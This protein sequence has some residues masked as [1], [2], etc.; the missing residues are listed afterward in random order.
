M[1]KVTAPGSGPPAAASGKEKR[2]FSKRLFPS[3]R[4]SGGGA[5]DSG[6]SGPAAPS[7]PSS[8][9]SVGSF[10]SRV[11][12]TLSTLSDFSSESAAP[13]RGGL[14]SCFPPGPAAAVPAA[15]RLSRAAKP[16]PGVAGLRNHCNTCFM[17]AMLQCLSNTELFAECLALGQYPA[18]RPEPSPH[19]EQPTGRGAQGQG[20]VTEQLA[21]LVRALWT[22]EYTS[23]HSRDF[24]TIVSKNALQYRGNS[25]HDAQEFLLWLLDRVHEDLNHSVKQSGQPP[26]KPLSETDMMPEGPSFPV[27]S[28]FVQELF[29]AQYRSSLTCPHCQKQSNSFDPF[30]CISLPI[31]LPTQVYQGKCSHCMRIG[32][33]VP[34]SGTVARLREAVS[35]ETKIPT[36]QLD[37][38]LLPCLEKRK[39]SCAHAAS[40][41]GNSFKQQPKPL[42]I[43]LGLS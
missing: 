34:L 31:P 40:L 3:R 9:R 33:A 38:S 26:L 2:S 22:L 10:M 7:S 20:E 25:Q 29:Q 35:M 14:C 17:N 41:L 24:K 5:G 13:D 30:L 43:W 37:Q 28:T 32:V 42:E 1:S 27:C 15:A 39:G 11:L 4:A 23:Q 19:P 8:A 36:D 16:V 21:H 18:G 12:K 6:A